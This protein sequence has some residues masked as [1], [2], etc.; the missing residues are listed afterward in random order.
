MNNDK[1]DANNNAK[2]DAKNKR[3]KVFRLNAA[4]LGLKFVNLV[5]FNCSLLSKTCNPATP[6]AT[7]SGPQRPLSSPQRSA[8]VLSNECLKSFLRMKKIK[9]K[10]HLFKKRSESHK[11]LFQQ[12]G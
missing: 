5:M 8:A 1:N 2:N 11:I 3:L 6:P 4:I 9:K 7:P 12:M 10:L